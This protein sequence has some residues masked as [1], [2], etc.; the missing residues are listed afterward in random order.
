[1]SNETKALVAKVREE[2][3]QA[4]IVAAKSIQNCDAVFRQFRKQ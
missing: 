2:N 4:I 3:R 1:M